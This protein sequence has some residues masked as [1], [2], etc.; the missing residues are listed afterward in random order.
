MV[1]IR[2]T[3]QGKTVIRDGANIGLRCVMYCRETKTYVGMQCSS[4]TKDRFWAWSG[5][6][7]QASNARRVF[8]I[9]PEFRVYPDGKEKEYD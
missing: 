7:E 6:R 5:T 3:Y 2:G 4:R 1:N 8:G 9:G